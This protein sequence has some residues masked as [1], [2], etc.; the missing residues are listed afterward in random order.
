MRVLVLFCLLCVIS[1][2]IAA[3][4]PS[5]ELLQSCLLGTP[6]NVWAGLKLSQDQLVRVGYIQDACKEEC[7]AAGVEVHQDERLFATEG[8]TVIAELQAVL[9]AEQYSA[10]LAYCNRRAPAPE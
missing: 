1:G 3:Q 9:S 2:R 10:W 4:E 7:E 8:T 5:A 6:A